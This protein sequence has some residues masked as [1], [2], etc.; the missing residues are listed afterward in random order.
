[1]GE[2]HLTTCCKPGSL[3]TLRLHVNV[4]S[5]T[6]PAIPL[7]RR[8]LLAL[9]LLFSACGGEGAAHPSGLDY[10]LSADPASLDPAVS[11]DVQSGEVIALLFD[12]LVQLD[13]EAQL[14]PG[15]ATRW[16]AD[17]SGAVYTFHLRK[18]ASFHDGRPIGAREVRASIL[19]ALDPSSKSG[20][21]WPLFPIKG[22]RA[23]AEGQ[24]RRVEGIEVP[25][26]STIV[27]TL[28]EPLNVFPKLLAMPVAAVA[29][30]PTPEDFDQHPVG[31]GPWKF[32]SWLHDDAIVLAKN[33]RYWAGPPKSDTLRIRI[34]P[35]ALTQ[36]AEYEA[37]NLSVVEIPF[38]E[39]RRWEQTH[40]NELQRR[41]TIR[42]LYIAINTT[43]GPLK[44]V[45]VRRALN[46]GTDVATVLRTA[47]SGRGVRSAGAIPPGILG[48][49]S[50]RAPYPWDTAGA[51]RLL[52]EAGYAN[53]FSLQLWRNK[54]AELVQVA[55]SVQQDLGLLGIRVEIVERDA[56]SVRATVRNG[57]ADL[58]LGDWY[59]D[60][61]DPENFTYPLFHSSNKG[62]GGN[63][64]FLSD[65]V[66]D[67]MI[68]RA[69]AT[70]DTV[71][72][73]RLSREID[74]RVFDLAPWIFLWFPID[75]WAMQ[76]NVVGW[77]IPAVFT[78]QR[79]ME[80]RRIR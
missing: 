79:W 55:Q 77:R 68:V 57:Q 33:P 2:P 54:R 60:Y 3:T 40:P 59:A 72:K 45:R 34:I 62:P 75:L 49:D 48:F 76:P 61:P 29:P 58:Y 51:R 23:Y 64:A 37:G 6:G 53:G 56:P 74:A 31:S 50:T 42:D 41:P 69:R 32:V 25:D 80:A 1:M 14:Q 7:L 8:P 52:K 24:A 66:L 20:R 43:R 16:E 21:Q 38:G 78:G 65:T 28:T 47:M 11:S 39:T 46:L 17:R 67:A 12:N 10:F 30:S 36:A 22:A 26:D 73:A 19:R 70:T 63:Y 35:E 18:G 9:A 27:F 15:L 5:P 13:P 44:D 4:G 71:E